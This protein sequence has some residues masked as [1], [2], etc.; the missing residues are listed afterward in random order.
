MNDLTQKFK[1]WR[2]RKKQERLAR[3]ERT[4]AQGK[5]RFVIRES[6][7]WGGTMLLFM[8]LMDYFYD[9]SFNPNKILWTLIYF[10]IVAPIITLATWWT[11]EGKFTGAKIDARMKSIKNMSSDDET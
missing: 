2:E 9:R 3:W 8:S 4:R 10:V 6:L 5:A 11:N 1:A 7:I